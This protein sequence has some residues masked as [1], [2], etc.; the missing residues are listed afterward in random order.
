MTLAKALGNGVPIGA[1][2]ASGRAKAFSRQ[3]PTVPLLVATR[4][5]VEQHWRL[6]M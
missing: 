5:L 2:L 3:V 4:W 6:S 1:C